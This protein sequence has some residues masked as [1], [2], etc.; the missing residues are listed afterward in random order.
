MKGNKEAFH[1]RPLRILVLALVCSGTLAGCI[2][3]DGPYPAR[4]YYY[5]RG[6]R[7]DFYRHD[8][9]GYCWHCGRW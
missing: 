4:G 2:V 8:R 5:Y 1:M 7:D 3:Y 6:D 9:D